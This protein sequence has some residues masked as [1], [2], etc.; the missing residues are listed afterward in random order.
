MV[1]SLHSI[2]SVLCC[3]LIKLFCDIYADR[4][5]PGITHQ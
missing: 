4:T 1:D 3:D 2:L 5:V